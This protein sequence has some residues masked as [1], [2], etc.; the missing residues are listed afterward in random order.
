MSAT[1][2]WLIA[3]AR[4]SRRRFGW[5]GKL[6]FESVVRLNRRLILQSRSDARITRRTRFRLTIHSSRRSCA[7]MRRYPYRGKESASASSRSRRSASALARADSDVFL[8]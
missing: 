8:A 4:K 2:T 5:I 3:V 6:C 7:A 1:Q